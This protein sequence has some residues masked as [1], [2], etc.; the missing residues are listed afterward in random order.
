MVQRIREEGLQ[1][2][3]SLFELGC[4]NE[5]PKHILTS[6]TNPKFYHNGLECH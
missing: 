2:H 1:L 3:I 5:I 6:V 4:T